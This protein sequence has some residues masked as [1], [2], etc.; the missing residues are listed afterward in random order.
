MKAEEVAPNLRSRHQTG[1]QLTL[2]LMQKILK[3][4]SLLCNVRFL[5]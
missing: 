5:T 3:E 4:H 1:I 2:Q